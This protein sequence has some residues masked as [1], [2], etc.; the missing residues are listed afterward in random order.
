MDERLEEWRPVRIH[1]PGLHPGI[2]RQWDADPAWDIVAL[3]KSAD[4]ELPHPDAA[5]AARDPQGDYANKDQRKYVF[6]DRHID[7]RFHIEYPHTTKDSP[8]VQGQAIG[9]PEGEWD[10]LIE[11]RNRYLRAAGLSV[12]S[13]RA[14]VARCLADTFKWENQFK[15]KPL[16][17]AYVTGDEIKQRAVN[18]P[19]E[20]LVYKAYCVGCAHAYVALAESC[21]LD[22]RSVGCG[23]HRVAE[24]RLN[25]RWHMIENGGRHEHNAGL[26]DAYFESSA[27]EMVLAPL[28]D[29]GGRVPS[30]YVDGL[31]GRPNGQYHFSCGTWQ[32]PPTLRYAASNAYALHPE[33]ARW[34]IKSPSPREMPILLN[35]NGFYANVNHQ[36]WAPR[37]RAMRQA[38]LPEPLHAGQAPARDHLY[39]SF[40]P[41]DRLRQSIWLDE[42]DDL[43]G[44]EVTIG[45]GATRVSDFSAPVGKHL[46]VRVGEF[47][48][49]LADLDAWPPDDPQNG[50]PAKSILTVPTEVLTANAVNWIELHQESGTLFQMPFVPAIKEPYIPPLWTGREKTREE[51][52]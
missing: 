50:E 24:V 4:G 40:H 17:E 33:L 38:A 14:D 42:L 30:G 10:V 21:G 22:A 44:L 52:P 5:R 9:D 2:A 6:W 23:A 35:A 32:G 34:G 36:T 25:G 39:H 43:D 47:A 11:Y 37:V 20:G 29:H 41:G 48:K 3:C 7:R 31:W 16:C 18:H 13:P 28:G 27:Q 45:F 12:D 15:D 49:S 19:V 51:A 26:V 1:F 8:R 46:L